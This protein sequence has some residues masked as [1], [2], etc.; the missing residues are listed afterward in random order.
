MAQRGVPH[1]LNPQAVAQPHELPLREVGGQL[2]LQHGRLDPRGAEHV[3]ELLP[4]EV[5]DSDGLDEPPIYEGLHGGPGVE[6]GGGGGVGGLGAREPAEGVVDLWGGE[7][8]EEMIRIRMANVSVKQPP[9]PE[10]EC[11]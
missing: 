9:C 2:D 8:E 10:R 7:E 11:G 5:A 1:D 6:E 4:G 3:L